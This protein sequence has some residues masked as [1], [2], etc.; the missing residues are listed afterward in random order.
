[1]I[2]SRSNGHFLTFDEDR[3]VY[4][5]DGEIVESVTTAG[6]GSMPTP[7]PLICW[8][9]KEGI[10]YAVNQLKLYPEQVNRLPD[11]V[12]EEVIKKGSVAYRQVAK[13]AAD[14]GTI[15]HDYAEQFEFKGKIDEELHARIVQHQDRKKI[16]VC[17]KKF[18][19]WKKANNDRIIKHEEI[20][21]STVY[22]FAGKFDRLSL[23]NGLVVL[24]DFKTSS[25]IY[26]EQFIQLAAYTILLEEWF[27]IKVD[28]I[29]IIRFGKEDG[30]FE[31]RSLKDKKQIEELKKQFIRN[32]ETYRFLKDQ[33]N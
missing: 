13:A 32:I 24:S 19:R 25:G 1:M 28:V 29:E 7:A 14:I 10:K 6:K 8:M 26:T 15:I 2:Q 23:R 16:F 18:R 4:I 3:H 20:C 17:V 5:L 9:V 11:Y 21:G 22:H 31:V 33:E 30:A 12:I 27:G